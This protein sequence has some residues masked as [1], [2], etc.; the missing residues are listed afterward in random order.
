MNLKNT[1]LAVAACGL[2]MAGATAQA[3]DVVIRGSDTMLI[4]NQ[5]WIEAFNK[6]NPRVSVTVAGGGSSIGINS[7]INGVANIAASSR[8]MRKSEIDRSRSRGSVANEIPVALDGLCIAVNVANPIKSVT[9]DQL[10]LIYTGAVT[11]WSQ[12]GLEAGAIS[13]LSRDQNSGT[14]GFFQANVLRNQNWGRGVRFM[15]STSDEVREVQSNRNAIAY[16]GVA[17]FKGKRNVKIVPV[18]RAAGQPAIM[19]DEAAVRNKSYPIWRYLYF[20]T[21]GRP[22]GATKTFIDFVLSPEGQQIAEGVGY[23]SLR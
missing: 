11:N 5:A 23:Y 21:N 12:L 4:L 3:A 8:P 13:A 16:G 10:R 17:Y 20:Y 7:F 1:V 6:K 9:M 2:V 18:A 19:P 15:P 14:F 22:S